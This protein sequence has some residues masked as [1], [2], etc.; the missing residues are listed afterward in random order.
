[1]LR[2]LA[3]FSKPNNT[4]ACLGCDAFTTK[5]PARKQM[6][7]PEGLADNDFI[8]SYDIPVGHHF[9]IPRR[10]IFTPL[11]K[12]EKRLIEEKRDTIDEDVGGSE[13]A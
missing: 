8:Q 12:L 1:M 6:V 4:Y 11:Q 5:E 10:L 9:L 3:L 2:N 7:I 13:L